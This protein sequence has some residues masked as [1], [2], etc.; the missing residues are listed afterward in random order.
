[1]RRLPGTGFSP[2]TAQ[3]CRLDSQWAHGMFLSWDRATAQCQRR[4]DRDLLAALLA[5]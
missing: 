1:M 4:A 5:H 2:Q 3:P